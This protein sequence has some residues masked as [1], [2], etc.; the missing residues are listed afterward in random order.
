MKIGV[1]T[2][3]KDNYKSL[4][5]ITS[6]NKFEYCQKHNYLFIEKTS[7]FYFSNLG[8]EKI[9]SILELLNKQNCD[10]IYWCGVDT[11]ITNF[12]IKITDIID[13]EHDFFIS[14]DANNINADSFIIKNTIDA[15]SF[16]QKILDFYPQYVY[17]EWAEQQ[18]IIDILGNDMYYNNITKI[19]PQKKLNS[20][21]YNIYPESNFL[22]AL[23]RLKN[24]QD[25]YGNDGQWSEGDFLI[26][27]PGTTL[28]QRLELAQKYLPLTLK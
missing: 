22:S 24:K 19:L 11:L 26:H 12:N 17:H 8:F 3:S 6:L 9:Y 1:F 18:A 2:L 5:D 14:T 15:R 4:R 25:F 20:Y 27:W 21:D 16:F 7:N 13:T 23:N 28:N 10:I